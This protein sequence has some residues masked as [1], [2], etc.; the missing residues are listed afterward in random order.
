M[1]SAAGMW[2]KTSQRESLRPASSTS[3]RLPGSALSRLARALPADPPPTMTKS[4]SC[5]LTSCSFAVRRWCGGRVRWVPGPARWSGECGLGGPQ[6]PSRAGGQAGLVHPEDG[7][8]AAVALVGGQ[9][10]AVRAAL[11][12]DAH[13][14]AVATGPRELY[15]A[16]VLLRPGV[17]DG[18]RR[19][20]SGARHGGDR[21]RGLQR[22]RQP[23]SR[24]TTGLPLHRPVRPRECARPRPTPS[25]RCPS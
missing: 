1:V 6:L 9:E 22:S 5:W 25:P 21:G 14:V 15:A 11:L 12:H 13:L 3:T 16:A 19:L 10:T 20:L 17:R 2:T 7:D 4:Y 24:R 18:R 23:T 8:G